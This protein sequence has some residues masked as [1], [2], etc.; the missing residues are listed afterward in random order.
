MSITDRI[1][2]N[3]S[4]GDFCRLELVAS[5]LARHR[6]NIRLRPLLSQESVNEAR[7]TRFDLADD[8]YRHRL[9]PL[10]R[11][12]GGRWAVNSL[13]LNQL[14]V[15]LHPDAQ[16]A[17]VHFDEIRSHA[18]HVSGV[19]PHQEILLKQLPRPRDTHL[20]SGIAQSGFHGRKQGRD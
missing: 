4:G 16:P 14:P 8:R 12:A 13:T 7:F 3:E 6:K 1:E 10:L 19:E 18:M 9:N 11:L 17:A 20:G 5:D 15:T 2:K